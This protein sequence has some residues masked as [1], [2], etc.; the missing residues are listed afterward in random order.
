MSYLSG[1]SVKA[2]DNRTRLPQNQPW[3]GVEMLVKN[4]W[5]DFRS[6]V[7]PLGKSRSL[8]IGYMIGQAHIIG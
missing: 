3:E 5:R 7:A 8:V 4:D 6:N 1:S 2:V